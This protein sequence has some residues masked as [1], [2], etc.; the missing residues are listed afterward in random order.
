VFAA[1]HPGVLIE[2]K[3]VAVAVHYRQAPEL[4]TTL[5]RIVSR[6]AEDLGHGFRVQPGEHVLEL[7]PRGHGKADAIAAFLAEAPFAGRL[8][9]FAGDDLTDLDGFAAVE[10]AGGVSISVGGRIRGRLQLSSPATFRRFLA[11][12]VGAELRRA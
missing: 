2:D 12:F 7:T 8:P 10:H 6:L 3:G 5:S 9:F 11:D 1:E 4:E